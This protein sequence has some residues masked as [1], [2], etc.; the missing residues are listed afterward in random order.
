VRV[1]L[2]GATGL[3]GQRVLRSLSSDNEV[4]VLARRE[5]PA[6][7]A[8]AT[9]WVRHDLNEPIEGAGLPDRV[10]AVVHLA[11]SERYRDFPAGAEDLFAV[12]VLSTHRLLEYARAAGAARFVF[13]STG[14]NYAFSPDPIPEDAPLATPGPYFR[15]KRMGELLVENYRESMT[16]AILRFF[17]V[18]GPGGRMLIPRLAKQILAGEEIVIEGEPGIRMNPIYVD[19]AAETVAAALGLREQ[20]VI[21]VAGTEVVT[22]TELVERL[23]A[24]LEREPVIRHS[25]DAPGDLVAETSRMRQ[26]LGAS[27]A[28][29]LDEGLAEV[30][31]AVAVGSA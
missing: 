8:E 5:A 4:V 27:P 15:S 13:A 18:Y 12:N 19:D 23:A 28:T 17:F 2:T 16:G 26:L 1:L 9:N 14:G 20:T 29:S 24:A 31:R 7:L 11:Q 22:L 6:E 21:N 30:A 3:I 25:G 10:D